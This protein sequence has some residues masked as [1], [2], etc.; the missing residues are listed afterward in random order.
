[1]GDR[2]RLFARRD[3]WFLEAGNPRDTVTTGYVPPVIPA[4]TYQ[5]GSAQPPLAGWRWR[6]TQRLPRADVTLQAHSPS[7]SIAAA[8]DRRAN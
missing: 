7:G 3:I 4:T 8:T 2:K 6:K 1:M 5:N